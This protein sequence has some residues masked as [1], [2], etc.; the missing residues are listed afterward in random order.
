MGKAESNGICI[1]WPKS[2][3]LRYT[4]S[5][6]TELA[7][8]QLDDLARLVIRIP[9]HIQ[10]AIHFPLDA[11]LGLISHHPVVSSGKWKRWD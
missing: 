3:H 1:Q 4:S 5:Y 7:L 11:Q 10:L 6:L 8:I 9:S 2:S